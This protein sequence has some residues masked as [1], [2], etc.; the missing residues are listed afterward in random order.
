M[1]EQLMQILQRLVA[2]ETKVNILM[3]INGAFFTGV[4]AVMVKKIFGNNKKR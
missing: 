1:T 2:V 4:I 3:I